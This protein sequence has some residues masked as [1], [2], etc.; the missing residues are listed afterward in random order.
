[1][2]AKE[3]IEQLSYFD[4]EDEVVFVHGSGDY[5]GTVLMTN[6]VGV[7]DGYGEYSNYHESYVLREENI[8][9]DY[10]HFVTLF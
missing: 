9:P 10:K 2:K 3:L 6:I 4:G 8:K 5:W 1:M 7:E